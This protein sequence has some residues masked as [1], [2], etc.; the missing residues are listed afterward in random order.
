MEF[1]Q[2]SIM[3]KELG[4]FINMRKLNNTAVYS[5][6]KEEIRR[7]TWRSCGMSENENATPPN[8]RG[9]RKA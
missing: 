9:A 1:N 3:G 6:V 2:K 4:K 7:T 8:L 5:K